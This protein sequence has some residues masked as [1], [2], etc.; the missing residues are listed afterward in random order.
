MNTQF[1]TAKREQNAQNESLIKALPALERIV[2]QATAV[3]RPGTPPS[4]G[5]NALFDAGEEAEQ[6][7]YITFAEG[8]IYL[9]TA[10]ALTE[11]LE[12]RSRGAVA[13]IGRGNQFEV[14]GLNVG[15]TGEPVLEYD[16]MAQSQK[17]TTLASIVSLVSCAL[18]FIYGYNETGARSKR[19]FASSSAW[20][21]HGF[22]HAGDRASEYSDDHIR[23]DSDRAG[24]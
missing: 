17:D 24:D 18:I 19:R 1:R 11:E 3:Q 2:T 12:R 16:E 10:H 13:G 20:L 23:A 14:P 15:V 9:V 4:P 5:V 22:H 7:I 8:R 6:Q 21:T